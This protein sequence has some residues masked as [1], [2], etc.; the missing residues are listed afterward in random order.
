L[1]EIKINQI[2]TRKHVAIKD[3]DGKS[4]KL[5]LYLEG[6]D[7]SGTVDIQIGK[8]KKLEH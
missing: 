6:D 5:P 8:G 1:I 7:I 2:D 3:K 4:S